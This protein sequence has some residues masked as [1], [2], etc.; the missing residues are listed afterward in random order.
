MRVKGYSDSS[1]HYDPS[2][3]RDTRHRVEEYVGPNFE[4]ELESFPIE[5]ELESFPI[6]NLF[7]IDEEVLKERLAKMSDTCRKK[8]KPELG[9]CVE[10][11]AN[12]YDVDV[13]N[14]KLGPND[15]KALWDF[16]CCLIDVVAKECDASDL[17]VLQL[18]FTA[19]QKVI[20]TK[21]CKNSGRGTVDCRA[22][23]T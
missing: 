12:R 10:R 15:C 6:A 17:S 16:M 5:E 3:H 4:E 9:K 18:G 14:D 11:A 7:A 2:Q 1:P 19:I 13:G 23:K 22:P 8:L 21:D 20:E